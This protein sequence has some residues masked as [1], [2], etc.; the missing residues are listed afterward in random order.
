MSRRNPILQ[1]LSDPT[2]NFLSFFIIGVV[3]L[4]LFSSGV[5]DLFWENL[6]AWLQ[7]NLN[8]QSLAVFRFWVLFGLLLLTLLLIYG[9]N[10]TDWVRRGMTKVGLADAVIPD[11]AKVVPLRDTCR[12]LVVIMSPKEDSPAEFAIRHHWH[13]GRLPCLEYC[14]IICTTESVDYARRLEQRLIAEGIGERLT[15]FYGEF[16]LANPQQPDQPFRLKVSPETIYDPDYVLHLV[17]AIYGH[18]DS[19]G[20]AETDLIVDIT[21]GTKPLGVGAFLACTRPERRLEYITTRG[22][23]R[24]IVEIR[25]AYRLKAVR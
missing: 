18:A 9:T 1:A 24:Q 25:V 12:G 22:E 8:I 7:T 2:K 4:N 5:S 17:N 11:T 20:I 23:S 3:L 14:W 13:Q 19:L 6:G 21:G 16:V 15:L 10:L